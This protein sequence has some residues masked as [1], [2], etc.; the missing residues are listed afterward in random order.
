MGVKTVEHP[1]STVFYKLLTQN[2]K[3]NGGASRMSLSSSVTLDF[4][5]NKY[6]VSN[7]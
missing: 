1:H 5:I 3:V 7:Q 2:H 4:M 6:Q